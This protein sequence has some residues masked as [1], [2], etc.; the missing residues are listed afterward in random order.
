MIKTISIPIIVCMKHKTP[1]SGCAKM[2]VIEEK[3]VNIFP[4]MRVN[5]EISHIRIIQIFENQVFRN[6]KKNCVVLAQKTHIIDRNKWNMPV[7]YCRTFRVLD[8]ARE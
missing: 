2:A 1:V 5:N 8:H 7:I 4:V 3:C 6:K